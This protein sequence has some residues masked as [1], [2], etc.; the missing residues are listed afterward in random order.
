MNG[1][2][3]RPSV[4]LAKD[5]LLLVG[6]SARWRHTLDSTA[7]AAGRRH[8]LYK[9]VEDV[10]NEMEFGGASGDGQQRR[11]AQR[12]LVLSRGSRFVARDIIRALAIKAGGVQ[13]SGARFIIVALF[14]LLPAAAPPAH[15][16]YPVT[17]RARPPSYASI[18]ATAVLFLSAV[19][20]DHFNLPFLFFSF[21][22]FS[23]LFLFLLSRFFLYLHFIA[24]GI[25]FDMKNSFLFCFGLAAESLVDFARKPI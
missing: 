20:V 23:F 4:R 16:G 15:I 12:V 25:H 17:C 6:R 11:A 24:H 8:H 7:T 22:F 2:Y 1:A 14:H 13:E 3:Y 9:M 19:M 5:E 10:V 18:P 21:L